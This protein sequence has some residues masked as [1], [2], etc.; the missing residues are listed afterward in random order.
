MRCALAGLRIPLLLSLGLHGIFLSGWFP[1][2]MLPASTALP[3]QAILAKAGHVHGEGYSAPA[4]ARQAAKSSRPSEVPRIEGAERHPQPSSLPEPPTQ[5]PS[6]QGTVTESHAPRGGAPMAENIPATQTLQLEGVSADGLREYRLALAREA[7]RLKRYPL[8]ARE[9]GW[10][11]TVQVTAVFA[12]A[13]QPAVTLSQSSGHPVLDE[14][15]LAMITR[16]VQVAELPESLRGRSFRVLVPVQ[17]S[18][19]D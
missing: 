19:D 1:H 10:E 8:L 4:A 11:G 7:R 2:S 14:Q 18:L 13:L 5:P 9:K 17:F 15:A 16:A 3:L 6:M 12:G